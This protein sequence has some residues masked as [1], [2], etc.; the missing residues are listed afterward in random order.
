ML[1]MLTLHVNTDLL[2]SNAIN[3]DVAQFFMK[4]REKDGYVAIIIFHPTA[5]YFNNFFNVFS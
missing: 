3:S 1:I 4:G 5:M 2:I